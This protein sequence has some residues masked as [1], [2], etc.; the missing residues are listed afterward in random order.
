MLMRVLII[1]C[2][3]IQLSGC[4]NDTRQNGGTLKGN[5]VIFHA[6]S[7]SIPI[8]ALADSFNILHPELNIRPEAAGSL[9]SIRKITELGK[10]CDILA[11]ADASMIDRLMMPAHADFNLEF[12]TNEMVI[13]YKPNSAYGKSI[14]AKNWPEIILKKDVIIGRADPSSDP[15]GYRTL[16][17]LKLASKVY[18][19]I[20]LTE[21]VL[22][23][24]K[25]YI[26]PKEVDLLALLETLS[27][28]YIFIY[29]SV[30]MQH[31]LKILHL[32]DSIN[33]GNNQ[34]NDWYQTVSVEIPGNSPTEII[35]M[36][37]EAMVYG[38]TMPLNSPN[39]SAAT[40]FINFVI[41]EGL[42]IIE[43]LHQSPINP[44]Q[45]S[46][47]SKMQEWM[48]KSTNQR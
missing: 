18:N 29:K 17:S 44:P 11:S 12:A 10:D 16:L 25:R 36:K 41:T 35:E 32:G 43:K 48:V 9:T 7:L 15:C 21:Q 46:K 23:K 40:E 2:I 4:S 34:L 22:N 31:G 28:D 3:L 1:L 19:N 13:A 45:L 6:G 37:G 24:D 39:R 14:T 47:S 20:N 27:V 38:L 26:R 33:L 8:K 42:P 5:L 30:A